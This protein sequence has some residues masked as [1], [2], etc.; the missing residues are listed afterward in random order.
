MPYRYT[1]QNQGFRYVQCF[2][3]TPVYL[4]VGIVGLLIHVCWLK[5]K[6][7]SNVL[8][9]PRLTSYKAAL[10]P[11]KRLPQSTVLWV[12][13]WAW[14]VM[15]CMAWHMKRCMVCIYKVHKM[16]MLKQLPFITFWYPGATSLKAKRCMVSDHELT[17]H[18]CARVLRCLISGCSIEMLVGYSY[19]LLG[20]APFGTKLGFQDQHFSYWGYRWDLH[21]PLPSWRW[22]SS[23]CLYSKLEDEGEDWHIILFLSNKSA[24]NLDLLCTCSKEHVPRSSGNCNTATLWKMYG[25]LTIEFH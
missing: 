20:R 12:F 23:G 17:S 19:F 21:L 1:G 4:R 3:S 7:T 14:M 22:K 15:T 24:P 18:L 2:G 16:C 13:R 10:A 25:R 11:A 6:S 5:H 8:T 9:A